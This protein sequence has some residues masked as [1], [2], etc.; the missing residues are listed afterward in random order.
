MEA[1]R[2]TSVGPLHHNHY[3]LAAE[4]SLLDSEL[5]KVSFPNSQ[6]LF[7]VIIGSQMKHHPKQRCLLLT[8]H[9]QLCLK[10]DLLQTKKICISIVS[11]S[12]KQNSDAMVKVDLSVWTLCQL[13]QWSLQIYLFVCFVHTQK[14]QPDFSRAGDSLQSFPKKVRWLLQCLLTLRLLIFYIS[15]RC[16]SYLLLDVYFLFCSLAFCSVDII[17][18]FWIES[19]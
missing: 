17:R 19:R 3:W 16:V 13:S 10:W 9:L 11:L 1:K 4:D 18:H 15:D 14:Y 8:S 2:E 5:E 6:T 12:R 7:V